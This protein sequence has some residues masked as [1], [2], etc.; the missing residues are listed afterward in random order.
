M[1]FVSKPQFPPAFIKEP[2]VNFSMI[3]KNPPLVEVKK[4]V[5][6][7]EGSALLISFLLMMVLLIFGMGISQLL[8][9]EI[10]VERNVIQAGQAYFGAE[11]GIEEAL[12][13]I[14]ENLPGYQNPGE[15]SF[16][17]GVAYAYQIKAQGSKVPCS[18]SGEEWRTLEVQE[19]ASLPLFKAGEE[20]SLKIENFKVEF[21]V[22][23]PENS[24]QDIKGK[25][26]RWK[27]LGLDADNKTEA[28]SDYLAAGSDENNPASFGA[29]EDSAADVDY[30]TASYYQRS[31]STYAFFEEYSID[32]FLDNHEANYLV[33]TNVIDLDSQKSRILEAADPSENQLKFRI[34]SPDDEERSYV[35]ED[36]LIESDGTAGQLQQS[37][38]VALKLGSPLPVFDF[39][40]YRTE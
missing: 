20:G 37:M 34:V 39:A 40:L 1:N 11:G 32:T 19:S 30:T 21:F 6:K 18:W 27:I 2:K 36:V 12:L 25:V 4:L 22:D 15:G 38:D 13:K 23:R 5:L 26:L 35:C 17:N 7:K 14:K 28:I 8:L 29:A 31:G 10:R 24:L 16:E 33:L 3:K 9:R